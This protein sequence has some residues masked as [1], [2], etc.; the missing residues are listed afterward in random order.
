[1]NVLI[2][3]SGGR[4]H[5][6][7]WKIS[8]SRL[9][10]KL[11][12]A[13]GNAGTVAHGTN[14][15]LQVNDFESIGTFCLE[16]DI[17][18]VVVG[19]EE[20]LVR[21]IKDYF[22]SGGRPGPGRD[23]QSGQSAEI[24]EN[25]T[26]SDEAAKGSRRSHGISAGKGSGS[27]SKSSGSGRSLSEIMVIGPDRVGALLEGSKAFAKQFMRKYGIPTARYLSVTKNTL[28]EGLGFL[29]TLSPPYV[30]K[31]DGLAAGKG[32]VIL[33]DRK[34]ADKELKSMLE[35]KFGDASS[36]VVI[37]EFLNGIELS[38]FVISDGKNYLLLPEAKDYK[39][40]GEND[41]GPNTGGMGAVSPVP[42]AGREF[43]KKVENRII[44]PTIRGLQEE[45]ID[46]RGFIFFGLINVAGNPF[47][48]EYNVRLGDPESEAIIPRIKNDLLELLASISGQKL[49]KHKIDID[50]RAAVSVMLV[51]GGYPG[52]YK[53]GLEISGLAKAEENERG[54]NFDIN[55][56]ENGDSGTKIETIVFHAGT[57]EKK[58]K[59]LT[60]GGRVLA[61]S[62]LAKT[63]EIA[64]ERS[65]ATAG[66]ISFDKMYFRKDLGMDLAEKK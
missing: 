41:T 34:E 62:T 54:H 61:V 55:G 15:Q 12:V 1:M 19:P 49:K 25:I 37:E 35:G 27:E 14:V 43:M 44:Q 6:L 32:V 20:P 58:G 65:Y 40:I 57:M 36:R 10:D 29:D 51:S 28:S 9:L 2:I 11:F 56:N 59:V 45:K 7:A 18:M 3:G 21:G 64:L 48:I 13:P 46:Y 53:K 50:P 31:A 16:M 26:G 5:A 23:L 52:D 63:M 4:E 30:L 17:D 66:L 60:S 24:L 42:F 38:V 22:T 33:E 39:R 8:Q 47:V